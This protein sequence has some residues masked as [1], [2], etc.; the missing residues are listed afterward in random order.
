MKEDNLKKFGHET[1]R[2]FGNIRKDYSKRKIKELETNSEN[3][4]VT[5]LYGSKKTS[6]MAINLK[7]T[8]R[9]ITNFIQYSS[10]KTK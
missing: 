10:H 7:P 4:N 8:W 9:H 5:Y 2:N 3:R 1:S 6:R